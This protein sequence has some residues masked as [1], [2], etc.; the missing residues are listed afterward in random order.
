MFKTFK[1]LHDQRTVL[2]SKFD[3]KTH[4]ETF[5]NYLEVVILE[6]GTVEY[7]TP[8]HQNKVMSIMS[9]QRGI[10][11]TDIWDMCPL[12]YYADVHTWLCLETK[13]IMVWNNRYEG[14]PNDKQLKS[15]L[16]LMD[17]KLYTGEIDI[18]RV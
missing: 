17:C 7:A 9:S 13:T 14:T 15:L 1:S 16:M 11:V 8:S 2:N 18:S 3:I 6:D 12:E 10:S 4:S 5:I